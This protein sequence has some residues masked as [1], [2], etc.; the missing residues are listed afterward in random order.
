MTKGITRILIVD[1]EVSIRQLMKGFFEDMGYVVFSVC[2]GESAL[3][4]LSQEKIHACI[5]D[6]RLPEMDGNEFIEKAYQM[7]PNL[8][9]LIHT[10]S[11]HY[12]LPRELQKIGISQEQVFRKPLLDINV[13][14]EALQKLIKKK[15]I[16]R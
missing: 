4:M 12:I 10:G 9:F 5:V 16:P 1:D 7:N 15:E 8:Y 11:T 2:D 14:E 13:L 6:I 3:E